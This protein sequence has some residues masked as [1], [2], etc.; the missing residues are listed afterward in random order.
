MSIPNTEDELALWMTAFRDGIN[1]SPASY[2]VSDG[3]ATTIS[4]AVTAFINARTVANNETTRT[5]PNIELKDAALASAD[6]VCRLFYGL[7]Q[8]NAGISDADKIAIGVSPMNPNRTPRPCPQ[9]SP[10]LNVVASTPGAITMEYYDSLNS[11]NKAKPFGATMCQ[12]FVVVAEE[13]AAT[14]ENAKFVG[15]FTTNPM[16]AVFDASERGKQATFFARW[17]G[18]RNEFGQWSVPVSMTIAA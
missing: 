17:G 2:F 8:R 4:N 6:G 16:P 5:K 11:G 13:N 14:P 1:A 7:I 15:N 9:G 3:D 18:K 10:G 12:L